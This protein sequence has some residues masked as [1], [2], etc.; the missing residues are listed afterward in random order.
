M[1]DIDQ[2]DAASKIRT[3]TPRRL[4]LM[5]RYLNE[6]GWQNTPIRVFKKEDGRYGCID[7]MHRVQALQDLK[8]DGIEKFKDGNYQVY[9]YEQMPE[10]DQCILA[11]S[12]CLFY[13]FR[14]EWIE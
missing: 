3:V 14:M 13:C 9:V 5:K 7:G 1:V 8:R 4:A 12:F 6:N 11:D 2:I 10:L